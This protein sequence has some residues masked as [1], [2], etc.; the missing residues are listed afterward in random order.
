MFKKMMM[1][2]IFLCAM[3]VVGVGSALAF[4]LW[5]GYPQQAGTLF[6]DDNLDFFTDNDGDGLI[7]AGDVL[8]AVVEFSK[9]IHLDENY[10]GIEEVVLDASIDD[11]V[12][13]STIEIKYVDPITGA[14]TMGE[15]NNTPM[16]QFYTG[17]PTNLDVLTSDPTLAAA[18]AAVTD[19]THLWDFSITAD[20]DTFW[21]FTPIVPNADNP[22]IVA[23]L[24]PGTKVG[25]LNYALNQVWGDDIFNDIFNPAYVVDDGLVDL[26]GSGDIL[27]GL[28]LTYAFA[29]SDVDVLLNPIPE[30]ATMSLLGL[31]LIGLAYVSRRRKS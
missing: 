15:L 22:A 2:S 27:G 28:G 18:V 5:P 23:A 12:A 31:G 20:P 9:A 10:L 30:P 13:L 26:V 11:L 19:G 6:E 24:L 29:R 4:P 21:N 1:L 14:M 3:L 25:V 16:V 7:S 17:G 8:T